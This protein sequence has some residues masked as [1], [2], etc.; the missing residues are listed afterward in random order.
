MASYTAR[1]ELVV[2]GRR[3]VASGS[4]IASIRQVVLNHASGSI[5]VVPA[6]A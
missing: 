1:A 4:G 2:L 6:G 5:A 3:P